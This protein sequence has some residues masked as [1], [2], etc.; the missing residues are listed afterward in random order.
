MNDGQGWEIEGGTAL[1]HTPLKPLGLPP[2]C[3][4]VYSQLILITGS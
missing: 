4:C 1:A 2:S 3:V